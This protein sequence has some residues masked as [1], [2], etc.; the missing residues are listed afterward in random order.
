MSSKGKLTKAQELR[1]MDG[2]RTLA[3]IIAR[4][5]LANPHLYGNGSSPAGG[6]QTGGGESARREGAA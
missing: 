4:H 6:R 2:L 1:R 5:Y 3:R